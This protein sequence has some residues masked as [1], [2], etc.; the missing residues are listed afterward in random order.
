MFSASITVEAVDILITGESASAVKELTEE[1]RGG[2][3]RRGAACRI[4][5][6]LVGQS[7]DGQVLSRRDHSGRRYQRSQAYLSSESSLTMD[8]QQCKHL[9]LG[10]SL[11]F[12]CALPLT[13]IRGH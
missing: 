1:K 6:P 10:P 2:S 12:V 4:R 5:G 11:A 7:E 13:S 9:V 3:Q 8:L